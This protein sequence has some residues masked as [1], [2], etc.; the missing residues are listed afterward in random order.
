MPV[1]T[2]SRGTFSGG[3][4]LAECVARKL[5]LEC[6]SREVLAEAARE[7][8]VPKGELSAALD[9]A[10]SF[11]QRLG[12]DRQR[13]LAYLRATLLHHAEGEKMIYHGHGGH[14]LLAGIRHVLRVLVIADFPS[15]VADAMRSQGF[16]EREAGNHIRR[17]D[18]D[19]RKWTRFLYR[20]EWRDPFHFDVVVNLEKISMA[21]ACE[22]VAHLTTLPSFTPTKES[23]QAVKDARLAAEAEAALLATPNTRL[24]KMRVRADRGVV[25]VGGVGRTPSD[26]ATIEEVLA[27]VEGITEVRL[28]VGFSMGISD[29]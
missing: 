23:R 24:R 8:G 22:T 9:T 6:V 4:E 21:D 16:T 12:W 25:T 10:P 29:A 5:G 19:R 7:F 27:D 15:R 13:Y 11:L 28:E 3:K 14:F 20:Q 17:V 18:E 2:I 26:V 1:V